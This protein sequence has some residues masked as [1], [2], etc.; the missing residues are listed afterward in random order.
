MKKEIA[1]SDL[2][3]QVGLDRLVLGIPYPRIQSAAESAQS[4]QAEI[5]KVNFEK[6]EFIST[7][8]YIKNM[9]QDNFKHHVTKTK[10]K[11]IKRYH[12]FFDDGGLMCTFTLGFCFGTAVINVEINPS[13]L[14]TQ[15]IKELFNSLDLFFNLGYQELFNKA[16]ISHAEF[17][18]DIPEVKIDELVLLD[19]SRKTTTHYKGTT[20]LGKR[21]APTVI[22]LYDK[23]NQLGIDGNLVRVEARIN[24]KDIRFSDF[25]QNDLFNPFGNVLILDINQLQ[26]ISQEFKK[27]HLA[28]HIKELGLSASGLSP[29]LRKQLFSSM[30]DNTCSWWRPNLFWDFHRQMLSQFKTNHV[31]GAS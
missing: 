5:A 4:N 7:L 26:S 2:I 30:Q 21:G 31:G 15:Q 13:K 22:V 18:V 3:L 10:N 27:P 29:T 17:Y 16:V 6:K 9:V 1:M 25:V 20:Y 14:S 23:A 19:S 11:D 28:A 8:H 12:V 24:R